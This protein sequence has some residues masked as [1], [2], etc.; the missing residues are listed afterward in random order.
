[1]TENNSPKNQVL[2][3]RVVILSRGER[4]RLIST[5]KPLMSQN[6]Y[7]QIDSLKDLFIFTRDHGTADQLILDLKYAPHL[8]GHTIR[9]LRALGWK[10]I[11]LILER[12]DRS[13]IK[14]LLSFKLEQIL[15][16]PERKINS[17]IATRMTEGE[18]LMMQL[19]ADGY[20]V[21]AIAQKL[22]CSPQTIRRSLKKMLIRLGYSRRIRLLSDLFREGALK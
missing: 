16:M 6:M 3:R 21:P 13:K 1:M 15:I 5:A 4:L 8:D 19:L 12:R 14:E 2:R 20:K 11:L 9:E 10:S 18:L 17:K 22:N 7:K